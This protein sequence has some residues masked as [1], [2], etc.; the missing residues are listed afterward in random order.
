VWA[1]EPV[2]ASDDSTSPRVPV[3][4]RS[5]IQGSVRSVAW[6]GLRR[7]RICVG[8]LEGHVYLS[9]PDVLT[10]SPFPAFTL[11]AGV[12]A[13]E[14]HSVSETRGMVAASCTDGSVTIFTSTLASHGLCHAITFQ[15]HAVGM[16]VWSVTWAPESDCQSDGDVSMHV[17][18]TCSEDHTVRLWAVALEWGH[19]GDTS[20]AVVEL[21][22][23]ERHV[24]ASTCVSFARGVADGPASLLSSSDD[25]TV[26]V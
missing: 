12:T 11:T 17:L 24:M 10:L 9:E 22:S 26:Q 21:Y 2:K 14:W 15:A 4:A 6:I 3:I 16:E 13:L 18:A 8:C 7:E 25:R 5:R 19:T 20:A 1:T 23:E